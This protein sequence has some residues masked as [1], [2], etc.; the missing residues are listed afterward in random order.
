MGF[1]PG[2]ETAIHQCL[3]VQSDDRCLIITDED[4]LPIGEA[5]YDVARSVT[6]DAVLLTYPPG[7]QHGEEPPDP[8]AGALA[9]A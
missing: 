5:L 3:D 4:R 2:A 8:V 7:D 6:D 9:E 1:Q